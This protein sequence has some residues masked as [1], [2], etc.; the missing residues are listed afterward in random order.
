MGTKPTPASSTAPNGEGESV[1]R[2]FSAG[3]E[4]VA[5]SG[6]VSQPMSLE[7]LDRH[8]EAL[9]EFLWCPVCGQEVFTHIPPR[10]TC[11]SS[12]NDPACICPSS[13]SQMWLDRRRT[14]S[15]SVATNS[16]N[17]RTEFDTGVAHRRSRAQ[18][19][20]PPTS[21]LPT[22]RSRP[23]C[24]RQPR[25]MARLDRSTPTIQMAVNR[26]TISLFQK[27]DDQFGKYTC[28]YSMRISQ[29]SSSR[30]GC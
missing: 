24:G 27:E 3:H 16:S 6:Q 30:I 23:R 25:P 10:L 18:S 7:V 12:V 21:R 13:E 4:V 2:C 29:K 22:H 28:E 19:G 9:F 1:G 17:S 20:H 14:Y 5:Q 15:E 8:S 26:G 11:I